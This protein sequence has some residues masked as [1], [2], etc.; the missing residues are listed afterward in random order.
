MEISFHQKTQKNQQKKPHKKK[1]LNQMLVL[2]KSLKIQN[3]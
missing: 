1:N 3:A 2:K